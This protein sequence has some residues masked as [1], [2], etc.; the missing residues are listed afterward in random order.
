MQDHKGIKKLISVDLLG[1][2]STPQA[3][4]IN[5][6]DEPDR[7]NG[8]RARIKRQSRSP[9]VDGL[10]QPSDANRW[11]RRLNELTDTD[12]QFQSDPAQGGVGWL[13]NTNRHQVMSFRPDPIPENACWLL[14][15]TDHHEPPSPL[16][17]VSHRRAP[18]DDAIKTRAV[19]WLL[20]LD[21]HSM[22][23]ISQESRDPSC[24]SWM[25]I[26]RLLVRN[27]FSCERQ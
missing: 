10:T 23:S 9:W 2:L 25:A 12:S 17:P 21:R 18:Q 16:A 27:R 7:C 6:I 24:R 14:I 11:H 26:D 19:S 1:S 4:S 13:V 8:L 15:R 3:Q 5:P 22:A 20:L